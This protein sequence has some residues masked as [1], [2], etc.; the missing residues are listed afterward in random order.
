MKT[1]WL[2]S[3]SNRTALVIFQRCTH[4][5]N[6]P[7][8]HLPRKGLE[9]LLQPQQKRHPLH[10][11]FACCFASRRQMRAS[12]AVQIRRPWGQHARTL[13][14][15]RWCVVQAADSVLQTRCGF[16]CACDSNGYKCA[17]VNWTHMTQCCVLRSSPTWA[18]RADDRR[19]QSSWD[20]I[21]GWRGSG[22]EE[23]GGGEEIWERGWWRG[24]GRGGGGT[25]L[26]AAIRWDCGAD[27][28]R[29]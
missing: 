20:E 4:Q 17:L 5:F 9:L 3:R 24:G 21:T 12:L 6:L 22:L 10:F 15:S 11:G 28:G 29:L 14:A 16:C 7:L 8:V 2:N 18:L 13:A 27:G 26:M 23:Q 1:A 19:L 25:E